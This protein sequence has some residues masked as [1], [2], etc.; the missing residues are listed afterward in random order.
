[1]LAALKI[2]GAAFWLPALPPPTLQLPRLECRQLKCYPPCPNWKITLI[3]SS[4]LLKLIKRDI[5]NGAHH[6]GMWGCQEGLNT[7]FQSLCS[8]N[9]AA[10]AP[11]PPQN[12]EFCIM[13]LF[14]FR[15]IT[16]KFWIQTLLTTT[17]PT[18]VR[19]ILDIISL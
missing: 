16:L 17:H 5:Q 4:Y 10:Q 18:M 11:T 13:C 15:A 9:K 7:K 12:D 6:S 19:A 14:I 2:K 3:F 1:M 8:K